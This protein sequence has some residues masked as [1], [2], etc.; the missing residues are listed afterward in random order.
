MIAPPA[1]GT[2]PTT[3]LALLWLARDRSLIARS[4]HTLAIVRNDASAE[5]EGTDGE[6]VPA[7]PAHL[8]AWTWAADW[9]LLA[10]RLSTDAAEIP[11]LARPRACTLHLDFI[12]GA[13]TG[14]VGLTGEGASLT[15]DTSTWTA[16]HDN[17]TDAAVTVADTG[18]TPGSGD[19]VRAWLTLHPDGSLGYR[20]RIND[21]AIVTHGTSAA[22]TAGIVATDPWGA[23]DLGAGGA[24]DWLGVSLDV[25]GFAPLQES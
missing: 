14:V 2:L 23:L 1:F 21:G 15:L 11:F 9:D 12:R 7:R 13:G 5:C 10:L 4:G 8:P 3:G 18:T 25:T 19:R 6:A 16:S 20:W 17:G 24:H 22:P